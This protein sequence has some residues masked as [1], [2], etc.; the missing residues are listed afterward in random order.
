MSD[1]ELLANLDSGGITLTLRAEGK[2]QGAFAGYVKQQ[3]PG[4]AWGVQFLPRDSVLAYAT[5]ESP[6]GRAADIAASVAYLGDW[7]RRRPRRRARA[8]AQGVR[9][10]GAVHRRRGRLRGVA[11]RAGGVGLGGAYRVN[12]PWRRARPSPSST[13]RWRRGSDRW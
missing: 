5:H 1:L 6:A 3:R 8:R 2:D 11:G 10:R 13:R 9:A 4:P 12:N 7:A